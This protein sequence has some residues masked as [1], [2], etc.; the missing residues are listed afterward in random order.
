MRRCICS[1]RSLRPGLSVL[2]WIS[3]PKLL[4]VVRSGGKDKHVYTG[5]TEVHA[6]V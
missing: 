4:Q 2:E 3:G 1:G 5:C 6:S